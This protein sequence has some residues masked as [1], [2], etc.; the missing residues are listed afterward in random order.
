MKRVGEHKLTW[1]DRLCYAAVF[2]ALLAA[3]LFMEGR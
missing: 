3:A 2:A 1:A